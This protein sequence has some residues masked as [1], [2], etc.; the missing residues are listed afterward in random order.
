MGLRL[1]VAAE[2]I[3]MAAVLSAPSPFRRASPL[4]H[5]DPMVVNSIAAESFVS[6]AYETG[7]CVEGSGSR[8]GRQGIS[9]QFAGYAYVLWV[10][11]SDS[12]R[13]RLRGV[14]QVSQAYFDRGL[15]S[16][17]IATVRLMMEYDREGDVS[18]WRFCYRFGLMEPR[19]QHLATLATSIGRQG[20]R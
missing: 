7:V 2:A 9:R 16:D 3:A 4:V 19:M 12:V 14:C 13:L 10:Q 15:F 17:T 6:F 11:I 18:S 1:G 20:R 8:K 5:T